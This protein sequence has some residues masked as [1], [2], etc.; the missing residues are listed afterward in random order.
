M[1]SQHDKSFLYM[2]LFSVNEFVFSRK[3]TMELALFI[4]LF[5]HL[6]VRSFVRNGSLKPFSS[7]TFCINQ[8]YSSL[9]Q[10][11]VTFK[12]FC[13]VLDGGK[14]KGNHYNN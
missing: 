11:F 9:A 1:F 2:T 7:I 13:L 5:I 8:L 14:D 4:H 10:L 3:V 12:T 6:S